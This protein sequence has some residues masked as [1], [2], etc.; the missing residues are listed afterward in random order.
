MKA[1]ILGSGGIIPPPRPGSNTRVSNEART[2]GI[3]YYRTGPSF[4]IKDVGLLFDCP[5][6]IRE[7]LNREG[8]SDIKSVI[9]THWHPDHTLGIRILE[10]YNWDFVYKKPVRAPIKVY[11]EQKQFEEFKKKSCGGFLEFYEEKGIIKIIFFKPNDT[12]NFGSIKVCPIHIK[13]SQGYYFVI[14]DNNRKIVYAPC[15]YH[16]LKVDPKT[17]NADIF[18]VHNLFWE[19]KSISPREIPPTDEDSF[20]KMLEHAEEMNAKK[21]IITHIEETFGLGH[22]D[23]N[24]LLKKKFSKFNIQAS[25]DG[26]KVYL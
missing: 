21:I 17:K 1:I 26:M 13:K 24:R 23:L 8:I 14:T 15:E 25:Y 12:L 22:D 20:E 5:E 6:E 10:Q 11:I 19:D 2:K 16:G 9:I 3:P 4:Y 7:Q 18:I